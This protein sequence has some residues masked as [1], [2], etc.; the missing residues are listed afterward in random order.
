MCAGTDGRSPLRWCPTRPGPQPLGEL[1]R[2]PELG[3]RVLAGWVGSAFLPPLVPRDPLCGQEQVP[4]PK[5]ILRP[6]MLVHL[7]WRLCTRPRP[8]HR[9]RP[10]DSRY[11]PQADGASPVSDDDTE[12]QGGGAGLRVQGQPLL[13]FVST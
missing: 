13:R 9:T 2:Q 8:E 10:P 11:S 4:V 1:P 12:G 7:G 5:V 3:E 6:R